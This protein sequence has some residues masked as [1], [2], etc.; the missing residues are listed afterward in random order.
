[1]VED[2]VGNL[3]NAVVEL[4]KKVA[5]QEEIISKLLEFVDTKKK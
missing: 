4:Q 5:F 2:I 1:M 3:Q